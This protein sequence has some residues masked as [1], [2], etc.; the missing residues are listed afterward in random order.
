[1]LKNISTYLHNVVGCDPNYVSVKSRMVERAQSEPVG[2]RSDAARVGVRNNVGRVE[3]FV[4]TQ[5]ADGTV[6]LVRAHNALAKLALV[7]SLAELARHLP[8]PDLRLF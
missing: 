7:Q 3:K 2:D 4:A 8:A 6:V 5:P 1:M